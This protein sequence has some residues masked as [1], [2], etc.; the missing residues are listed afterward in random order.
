MEHFHHRRNFC[1]TAWHWIFWNFLINS[2]KITCELKDP[3]LYLWLSLSHISRIFEF[4]QKHIYIYKITYV[5]AYLKIYIYFFP[6]FYSNL[7]FLVPRSPHYCPSA[8]CLY[9]QQ[10]S[11]FTTSILWASLLWLCIAPEIEYCIRLDF[12]LDC[13]I[14]SLVDSRRPILLVNLHL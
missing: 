10:D 3:N 11:I 1:C 8:L 13:L 9:T 2:L 6:E 14:S 4:Y 7:N 5:Y 12:F